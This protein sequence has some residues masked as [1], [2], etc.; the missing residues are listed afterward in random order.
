M[1]G[2]HLADEGGRTCR[3]EGDYRRI[4]ARVENGAALVSIRKEVED[5]EVAEAVVSKRVGVREHVVHSE[6]IVVQEP[7]GL[8]RSVREA[9]RHAHGLAEL[10]GQRDGERRL[11]LRNL[12][13]GCGRQQLKRLLVAV[14][15]LLTTFRVSDSNSP[16]ISSTPSA[17][18]NESVSVLL[19]LKAT[20]SLAQVA[21][22][23]SSCACVAGEENASLVMT[24]PEEGL[25]ASKR[26]VVLSL[27]DNTLWAYSYRETLG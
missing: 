9:G 8:E 10:R 22:A 5:P 14:V 7:E 4:V 25:R 21:I 23:A 13:V 3:L 24:G 27:M 16:G 12:T 17:S 19:I 26:Y 6:A 15:V 2:H 18:T 20:G 11:R 1:K